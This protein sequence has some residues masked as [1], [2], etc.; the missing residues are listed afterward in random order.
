MIFYYINDDAVIA[1]LFRLAGY[2]YGPLLGL[3][4]FGFFVNKGVNDKMVPFI[5]LL[6]PLVTYV[7]DTFSTS[8]LW[9]Y[10]FGFELLILNGLLT[11]IGML[12][13]SRKPGKPTQN[14]L[15]HWHI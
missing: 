3:Y 4:A 9:G 15:S 11:F 10:K 13:V 5:C 12:L 7:L 6:S 8:L 2:T 1:A 14:L